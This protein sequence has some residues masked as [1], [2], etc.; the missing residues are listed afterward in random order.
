LCVVL[1]HTEHS[2]RDGQDEQDSE[3]W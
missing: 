3:P 2:N 1:D